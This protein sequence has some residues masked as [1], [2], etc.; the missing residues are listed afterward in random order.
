MQCD[1]RQDPLD[2]RLARRGF[3]HRKAAVGLL[4][5]REVLDA[6][7]RVVFRG[8]VLEVS[9]WVN[10]GCTPE[11]PRERRKIETN[12]PGLFPVEVMDGAEVAPG[13][14]RA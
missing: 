4:Y 5:Q 9:R 2:V 10:A 1:D 3:T 6:D 13:G 11:P 8:R 12:P 7:G 14:G